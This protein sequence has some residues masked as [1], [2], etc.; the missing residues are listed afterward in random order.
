MDKTTPAV[1]R[2]V[3]QRVM[4]HTPGPWFV[5][6]PFYHTGER[7]QVTPIYARDPKRLDGRWLVAWCHRNAMP[8]KEIKPNARLIAATPE[9]LEALQYAVAQ[10]PELATVP[11]IAAAMTKAL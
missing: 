5:D 2:Q 1:A 6:K 3:E 10:A 9:L 4:Q 8:E 7:Q 11:G